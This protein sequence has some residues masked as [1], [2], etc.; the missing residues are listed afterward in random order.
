MSSNSSSAARRS[1]TISACSNRGLKGVLCLGSGAW[2]ESGLV[3]PVRRYRCRGIHV[4]KGVELG[5]VIDMGKGFTLRN[6]DAQE[7]AERRPSLL[8]V[9][10][11]QP[12]RGNRLAHGLHVVGKDGLAVL[13]IGKT[14]VEGAGEDDVPRPRGD[15]VIAQGE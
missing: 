8:D 12:I 5:R 2:P 15:L 9:K 10:D 3:P 4:V 13:S 6:G 14:T 11:Q 7:G 1:S